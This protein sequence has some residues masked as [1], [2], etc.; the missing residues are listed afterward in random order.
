MEF[1]GR[2]FAIVGALD[3]FPVR[4][5]RREIEARGGFFRRNLSRRLTYA[6]FGHRL[7][8]NRSGDR[9][10][11]KLTDA[12]KLGIKAISE[13]NFL[14]AIGVARNQDGAR[15]LTAYQLC[16]QSCLSKTEFELLALFDAFDTA[17]EPFGFRD[18]VAAKQYAGLLQSGVGWL[19][20][21]Q[22]I[23]ASG[24]ADDGSL[25]SVRL[26]RSNWNDVVVR[27][28]DAVIELDGQHILPL[29]SQDDFD[30]IDRM[31]EKAE[32]AESEEDWTLAA[33]LYRR[34]LQI[35]GGDPTFAFNLSHALMKADQI[36]EAVHQLHR[37]LKID[38]TFSEAWYNLGS[39]ASSRGET[40]S[41]K[42]YF[43]NAIE[44]DPQYPDPI[45]NLAL[46]EFESGQHEQASSWWKR[47]LELDPD[48]V[49]AQKA[50]QGLQLIEMMRSNSENRSPIAGR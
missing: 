38:P 4:L 24:R 19:R 43:E 29:P 15:E 32:E 47:Y 1:E 46:A 17:G 27:A 37:T 48:T 36:E 10:A 8:L 18:L 35:D 3:A 9:I 30:Q 22:K 20:L 7:A 28:G 41:A 42:R 44:I 11:E 40:E 16:Q 2:G 13:Q 34:C 45:Y 31:C 5:A 39:I 25:S 49:W 21:V 33:G 14:R 12:E 50:K 6:V 26:E 23:R